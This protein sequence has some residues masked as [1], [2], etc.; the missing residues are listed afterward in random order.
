MRRTTFGLH[1]W[2]TN[3]ASLGS[4]PAESMLAKV[5]ELVCPVRHL[6][7]LLARVLL[8]RAARVLPPPW[9]YPKPFA[10]CLVFWLRRRVRCFQMRSC[11]CLRGCC[12]MA[13]ASLLFALGCAAQ[14]AFGQIILG[15]AVEHGYKYS[16]DALFEAGQSEAVLDHMRHHLALGPPP[17]HTEG[18]DAAGAG[19]RW[20]LQ[21]MNARS[22][23]QNVQA[24]PSEHGHSIGDFWQAGV[25]TLSR[26]VMPWPRNPKP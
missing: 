3:F 4:L 5:G 26:R 21:V 18:S 15:D 23:L 24:T 2:N 16:A 25:Q 11:S 7:V 20:Q 14:A 6:L 19:T 13:V 1:W 17:G 22:W 9:Q 10:S 12:L 8:A